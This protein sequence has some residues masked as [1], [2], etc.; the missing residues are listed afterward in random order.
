MK[1]YQTKQREQLMLFFGEHRDRQY[2]IEQLAYNIEGIGMSSL[3]RNIN[4]LVEEGLVRRSREGSR[5]FLYQY[6]GGGDCAHHLHMQCNQCGRIMHM[7]SKIAESIAATVQN[8]SDFSIDTAQTMLFGCCAD[9]KAE[10][11]DK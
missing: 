6:I 8:D 3:Y 11:K 10:R 5:K 1:K 2:T 7:D 4:L 9:C